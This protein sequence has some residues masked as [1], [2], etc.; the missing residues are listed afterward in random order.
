MQGQ[1][2]PPLT[3]RGEEQARRLAA[4]LAG[5]RFT[6]FYASDLRRAAMTASAVAG[7][8][9][10]EPTPDPYLREISLGDWE[11][12]TGPEAQAAYPA[13][14]AAWT[15]E[16]SWDLIPGAEGTEAF[17][18]RVAG[19]M[20]TI[21][22]RHPHGDVLCVTHGGVIQVLLNNVVGRTSEGIF[23]FV[24][25]NASLTVLRL[26]RGRTLVAAVNDTCHLESPA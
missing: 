21:I 15:R 4:R 19:A 18:R 3:E 20:A 9:G 11:G 13:E 16:P 26:A 5:R 7:R 12:R 23:P 24:I 10:M 22:E 25:R 2:D 17:E 6:A 8:I 14:W 1:L